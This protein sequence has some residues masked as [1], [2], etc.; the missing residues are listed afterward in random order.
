[1]FVWWC[2]TPLSTIFLSCKQRS[3]SQHFIVLPLGHPEKDKIHEGFLLP[4]QSM[5]IATDVVSSN[6]YQSEVYNIIW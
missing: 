6:L 2:L 3:T 5:H 4:M 1:L